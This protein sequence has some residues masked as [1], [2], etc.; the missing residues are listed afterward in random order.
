MQKGELKNMF[1]AA[2]SSTYSDHNLNYN[3]II[4]YRL[5]LLTWKMTISQTKLKEHFIC[6]TCDEKMEDKRNELK[7]DV[8]CNMM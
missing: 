1:T 6:C 3:I 2:Y 4:N 5:F 7:M 8:W